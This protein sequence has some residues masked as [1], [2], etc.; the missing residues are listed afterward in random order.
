MSFFISLLSSFFDYGKFI[1]WKLEN[2]ASSFMSLW[3]FLGP[4]VM[5]RSRQRRF[6][7]FLRGENSFMTFRNLKTWQKRW[8]AS[9]LGPDLKSPEANILSYFDECE[10]ILIL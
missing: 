7:G 10:C 1:L 2:L 4:F 6:K 8:T 3:K 5:S 9:W